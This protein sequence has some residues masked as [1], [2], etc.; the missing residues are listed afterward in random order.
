MKEYILKTMDDGHVITVRD[1][2][3]VLLE[4]LKMIDKISKDYDIPYYL[5]GGSALGAI[6]HKGLFL[7][8]MMPTL[9]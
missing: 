1:V 8:M 5:V 6:R 9:P 4:M 3:M 7:G 2:Q